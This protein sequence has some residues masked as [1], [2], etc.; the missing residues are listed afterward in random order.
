M[1]DQRCLI[2]CWARLHTPQDATTPDKPAGAGAAWSS[3]ESVSS[4]AA[5]ALGDAARSAASAAW[6]TELPPSQPTPAVRR[7]ADSLPLLLPLAIM[8]A[9]S[10]TAVQQTALEF[11]IQRTPCRCRRLR[12]A[13]HESPPPRTGLLKSPPPHRHTRRHRQKRSTL[14]SKCLPTTNFPQPIS[15]TTVTPCP[16]CATATGS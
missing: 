16:T 7:L 4:S 5:P 14:I 2:E 13:M 8:T 3:D 1:A 6:T 10:P 12:H 11:Q 9:L 15:Q